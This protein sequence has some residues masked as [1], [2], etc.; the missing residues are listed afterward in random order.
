MKLF[1]LTNLEHVIIG[2]TRSSENLN[3]RF[4]TLYCLKGGGGLYQ[5]LHDTAKW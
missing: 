2:V 3:F 5:V 4:S 1:V